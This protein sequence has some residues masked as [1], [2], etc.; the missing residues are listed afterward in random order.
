MRA[1]NKRRELWITPTSAGVVSV[2][3]IVVCF[4]DQGS[5]VRM[6]KMNCTCM[7]MYMLCQKYRTR[8]HMHDLAAM[9]SDC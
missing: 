2:E 9:Q 5:V 8:E 7:L 3:L 6:C 4:F 1:A